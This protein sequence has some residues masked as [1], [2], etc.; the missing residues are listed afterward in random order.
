MLKLDMA[1]PVR[2]TGNLRG[3]Q[4]DMFESSEQTGTGSSQ[5]VAHSL[6]FTPTKVWASLTGFTAVTVDIAYGTHT[7]TNV[8]LTVT[9]AVTFIVH[10]Y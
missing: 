6:G 5:N 3:C 8:V 9:C 2:K 4:M 10:A 7:G 1:L